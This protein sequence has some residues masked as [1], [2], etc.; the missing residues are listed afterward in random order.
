MN[1]EIEN[2]DQEF[3][4]LLTNMG[5]RDKNKIS[6]K[7]IVELAKH[8]EHNNVLEIIIE[9]VVEA[10]SPS[11]NQS[12]KMIL[13]KILPLVLDLSNNSIFSTESPYTPPLIT[14]TKKEMY[15]ILNIEERDISGQTRA[16]Q[17]LRNIGEKT[18]RFVYRR[19]AFDRKGKSIR[20]ESG[21]LTMETVNSV[22]SVLKVRF[23]LSD[24][25]SS[26]VKSVETSCS[27]ALLSLLKSSIN[28][29]M[30]SIEHE[31]ALS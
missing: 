17:S 24:N 21:G 2:N 16:I 22:D 8:S 11:L 20:D 19:A 12:E 15:K 29:Y 14:L 1:S 5:F 26:R 23:V 25:L 10:I 28:E 18:V 4:E 27:N 9:R 6:Q 30:N 3:E 31:A 7:D 13:N